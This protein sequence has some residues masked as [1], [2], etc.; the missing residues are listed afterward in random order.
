VD[1]TR[2]E[3]KEL[4]NIKVT[5]YYIQTR[6]QWKDKGNAMSK[7]FFSAIKV[8]STIPL[9]MALKDRDG[10][11]LTD[12]KD[13]EATCYEFNQALYK[14]PTPTHQTQ[15]TREEVLKHIPTKFTNG[16]NEVL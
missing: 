16:M 6:I 4:K 15:Q 12:S 13:V 14:A 1:N 2:E 3:L 9:I 11:I 5:N 7:D 10:N 8:C